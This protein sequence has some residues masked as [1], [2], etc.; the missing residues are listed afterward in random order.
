MAKKEKKKL[1]GIHYGIGYIHSENDLH[2]GGGHYL[3][4][5][6]EYHNE[7]DFESFIPILRAQIFYENA[8]QGKILNESEL[9]NEIKES[10]E[11]M[12]TN[13]DNDINIGSL[14]FYRLDYDTE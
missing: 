5:V 13:Y 1:T 9:E 11:I 6:C 12:K 3:Y 10:I 2:I 8:K 7:I 14:S 4:G